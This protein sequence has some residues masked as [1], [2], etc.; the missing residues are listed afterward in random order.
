VSLVHHLHAGAQYQEE[1]GVIGRPLGALL[2]TLPLRVLYRRHRFVCVSRATENG[3]VSLGIKRRQ[4]T[5]SHNGV[6]GAL[7][8]DATRSPDPRFVVLGRIKRYKRIEL[9]LDV[10]AS[11]PEAHLDIVGDGSHTDA[12][13]RTVQQLGLDERVT[14][15]GYVDEDRKRDLLRSA[16]ANL[17]ASAAEGWG[18]T[19]AEAAACGTPSVG[20]ATGGLRE[21][22]V[23][24]RTGLLA[25]DRDELRDHLVRLA[26]DVDL[27]EKLGA[28]AREHV[29]EFTWERTAQTTL[30]ALEQERDTPQ[31]A[32]LPRAVERLRSNTFRA[33]GL[34]AAVL[35]NSAIALI[36]T[37]LFAR[38]L[39]S[40]SYGT[41]A[42][43]LACVLMLTIPGSALQAAVAR[44]ISRDPG[45]GAEALARRALVAVLVLAIP[46]AG[47]LILL[48][49]P[50]ASVLGVDL[51]WAS[52]AAVWFGWLWIGLS[53]QRGLFQGR[54]RYRPLALSLVVEAI[55]R[56]SFGV[57]LLALGLGATGALLATG[58]AIAA[59]SS[60]LIWADRGVRSGGRPADLWRL[61]RRCG[62]PLIALSLVAILQNAD[63]IIVRHRM[64]HA[65]AGVYAETVVAARGILWFG[66][67]LGLFLLPE[68]ARRARREED[69]RSILLHMMSLVCVVAVPLTAVYAVLGPTLL[70]LVFNTH[71]VPTGTGGALALLS[72]AMTLL[73]L[74][75]LVVQYQLALRRRSFVLPLLVAALAES[76]AV[77]LAAPSFWG[78]AIAILAVQGTLLTLLL[79]D[80]LSPRDR[81]AELPGALVAASAAGT[82]GPV[83]S[84][85]VAI[86]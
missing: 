27:V 28:N 47:I 71:Q 6:D 9:L 74:S 38:W 12:V 84:D 19:I 1:M 68:A 73:A 15:H 76:V 43:L 51:Q 56:L 18:L 59:S 83:G 2:E 82:G 16:W 58:F 79:G 29:R 30:T 25:R 33:A 50:I 40:D 60:L 42:S 54:R 31:R 61:A 65:V 36:C 66:V 4:I 20:L 7:F 21:A 11:V 64:S 57:L 44:D 77:M 48:R 80:A 45:G 75:Y 3:L 23:H 5:V 8:V 67:G 22:I 86:R 53:L 72:V 35:A 70:R 62:A 17:T 41:V 39:G 69:A 78:I 52:A 32:L 14:F 34:A 37:V 81:E 85:E 63:V 24:E 26:A 55:G 10:L 13:A 49:A 46:V